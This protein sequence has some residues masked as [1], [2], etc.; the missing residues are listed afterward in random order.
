MTQLLSVISLVGQLPLVHQTQRL[1]EIY[2]IQAQA[3]THTQDIP[4]LRAAS[5]V[6]AS[7]PSFTIRICS[8]SS[9]AQIHF[10]PPS[11][12]ILIINSTVRYSKILALLI[13]FNSTIIITVI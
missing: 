12:N 11:V 4:F 10:M 5:R 6:S 1:Q 3:H 8:E 9:S 7:N 13:I 2:L